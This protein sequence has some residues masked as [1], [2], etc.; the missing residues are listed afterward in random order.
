MTRDRVAGDNHE[1]SVIDYIVAC[2]TLAE[3]LDEML[4]DEERLHVLT[5]FANKKKVQSDHNVVA[6]FD[7]T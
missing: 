5:K 4:I 3:L 7:V 6:F 1:Q 2:D